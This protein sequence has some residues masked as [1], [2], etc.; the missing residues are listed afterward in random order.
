MLGEPAR[1]RQAIPSA[2]CLQ[3]WRR[4]VDAIPP[5]DSAGVS[6]GELMVEGREVAQLEEQPAL[7][8]VAAR[9][10]G[11]A[12]TLFPAQLPERQ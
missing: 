10:P 9:A 5:G 12:A 8:Q 2:L 4:D 1:R 3:S 7:T 11:Q 6:V